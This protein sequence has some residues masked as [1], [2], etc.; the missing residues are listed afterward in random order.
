MN[1]GLGSGLS[2]YVKNLGKAIGTVTPV[3][4]M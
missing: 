2:T 1:E 3:L 4:E